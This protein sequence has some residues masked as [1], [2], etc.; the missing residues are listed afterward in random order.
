M[1]H[2]VAKP[3]WG[4]V[5]FDDA[6]GR[7]FVQEDWYYIWQ[8]ATGVHQP[9]TYPEKVATHRRIDRSIWGDWSNRFKLNVRVKSGPPLPFVKCPV[10]FD[11]RWTV[12]PPGNWTVTMIKMPPN[13]TPTTHVSF[14]LLGNFSIELDTADFQEYT[15]VND[16]GVSGPGI[17]AV[18][19][20]FGHTLF[21]LDE[22]KAGSPFIKDSD[23][24]MNIGRQVR[25]HHLG[26][27]VSTLNQLMP[28]LEFSI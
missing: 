28:R 4:T 10:N 27:I 16:I 7:I 6:T 1:T 11:V 14:V 23:S 8:L 15:G 21:N 17:R 20:E 13:A 18:P 26:L 3:R 2:H 19:H 24:I 22:Y 12:K 5:D 9:W 25:T